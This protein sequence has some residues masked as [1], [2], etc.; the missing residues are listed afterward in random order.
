MHGTPATTSTRRLPSFFQAQAAFHLGAVIDRH[1]DAA[2]VAEEV[3]RVQAGVHVEHVALDPLAAVQQVTQLAQ[4]RVDGDAT[5]RLDRMTGA[6]LV[7]HRADAADAR[8]DVDRLVEVASLQEGFEEARW[9]ED[10]QLHVDQFAFV[11]LDE[12]PPS[13]SRE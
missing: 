3:G 7:R 10:A 13:P 2:R 12:E 8:R 9:L 5:G 1:R 11:D 4:L 6:H